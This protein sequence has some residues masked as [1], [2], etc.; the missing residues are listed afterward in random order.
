MAELRR[1]HAAWV[2]C[3]Q[4]SYLNSC[5]ADLLDMGNWNFRAQSRLL[6]HDIPVQ[7]DGSECMFLEWE[8]MSNASK[9][10]GLAG[11]SRYYYVFFVATKESAR[12]K[13]FCSAIMRDYQAIASREGV[14]IWLE[15]TTVKSMRIYQKLGW[16]VV[17][18]LVLGKGK[19]NADGLPLKGGEGVPVWGMVWWPKDYQR[20]HKKGGINNGTVFWLTAATILSASVL[21]VYKY[22]DIFRNYRQ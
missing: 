10:K 19:V 21:Y 6:P 8:P 14:P 20:V 11:E 17:D 13:G 5:R 12:G 15:A 2:S 4:S 22:G 1:S 18:E 16:E 7:A 3:R 9:A